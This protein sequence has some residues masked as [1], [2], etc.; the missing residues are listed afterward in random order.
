MWSSKFF[1]PFN[2]L[3]AHIQRSEKSQTQRYRFLIKCGRLVN[4][5][6]LEF[7][8][9]FSITCKK[10]PLHIAHGY[11]YGFAKFHN[12]M[13][14]NSKVIFKNLFSLC[15]L[16]LIMLSHLSKLMKWL[17]RLKLISEGW[18]MTF[19]W[20]KK[21]LKLCLKDYIF[22]SYQFLVEVTFKTLQS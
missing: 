3:S 20:N 15:V 9:F 11:I 10:Y 2:F 19:T 17:N 18:N 21:I 22:R 16:K 7:R 1:L 12:Q 4:W 6:W 5:K 13:I 14:Y 8:V